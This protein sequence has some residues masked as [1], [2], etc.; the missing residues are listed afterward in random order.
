MLH[1]IA[2]EIFVTS[3]LKLEIDYDPDLHAGFTLYFSAITMTDQPQVLLVV[4]A[5]FSGLEP[6][7]FHL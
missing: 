6:P 5:A 4:V 7:D 1:Q 3:H 2:K